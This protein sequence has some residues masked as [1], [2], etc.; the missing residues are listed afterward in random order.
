M[1][2]SNAVGD[3]IRLLRT[4]RSLTLREVSERSK[5]SLGHLSEIEMGKKNASNEVLEAIAVGLDLS[6]TELIGEVHD[7]LKIY[8]YLKEN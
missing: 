3:T 7:Y 6:T 4:D 1:R 8:D 2:L 5:V